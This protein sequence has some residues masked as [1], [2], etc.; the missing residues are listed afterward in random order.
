MKTYST[1]KTL[2]G[3]LSQNQS[4]TN[5]TLG[6]QIIS[7]AHRYLIESYFDNERTLQMTTVG[8]QNLT[9]T[10]TMATNA[11][12]ATLTASWA[13]P[14]VTQLVNFSNTDQRSVLFTNGSTAIFIKV[15][16]SPIGGNARGAKII[17]IIRANTPLTTTILL[18]EITRQWGT[19]RGGTKWM[20]YA[21][22]V[23]IHSGCTTG[24]IC[25]ANWI[26]QP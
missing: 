16:D 3:S 18:P 6:G 26:Y 14:T 1:L 25:V 7:D 15:K 4:T 10:A 20:A 9:T 23:D 13:N 12:S 22:A 19:P 5:L 24:L 21:E 17:K 8:G 2:F 11:T